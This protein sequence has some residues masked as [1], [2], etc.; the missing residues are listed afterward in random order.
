MLVGLL[1]TACGGSSETPPT[2]TPAP[3]PTRAVTA[4][5]APA[6]YT[7]SFEASPVGSPVASPESLTAG[8]STITRE[9]FKAQLAAAY[10]MEAAASTGGKIVFGSPADISTTNPM[11]ASDGTTLNILGQVFEP[12]LGASPIDGRPVPALADSWDVSPDGL[13]FTFHLNKAAKW[14]DGVDITTDDVQFSFDSEL[15]PN[16]GSPY[17]SQIREVIAS[18]RIIDADT[19]EIT[20]ADRFVT[21]LYNGPASVFILPKHIWESVPVEQWSFNGGSTGQDLARVVGSGPFLLTGWTVGERVVLTRNANYYDVVPSLDEFDMVIIPQA[22]TMVQSLEQGDID[23]VEILPAGQTAEVQANTALTVDVYPLQQ[24]TYYAMNLDGT[25]VP[26]F[27]DVRVRQAL[28]TSIDRQALTDSIFEG[29]GEPAR[30]TQ[31]P[32]SPSYDP[33]SLQPDYVYNPDGARKLLADAGWTDSNNNGSVDKDGTELKLT[34]IYT[35]GDSTVD[36]MV[37]YL[38]DAWKAIG[39]KV[40]ITNLNGEALVQRLNDHDFDLAILAISLSSDGSQGLLFDCDSVTTGFNFG[41]YCNQAY[42]DLDAQQLREF[43]PDKRTQMQTELAQIVW[44]D[45]P[46]GPIRFGVART[47]YSNRIHNFFPNGFGFLW[48][49]SYVWVDSGS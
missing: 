4:T 18:Y 15:N 21:F 3:M 12:L 31:P 23:L 16:L 32:L 37:E 45:L 42:D 2:V 14:S 11:L 39:V 48:S 40:E 46:V 43:D 38:Q 20:A 44:T 17:R 49:L 30:G 8:A 26:A 10:P 36:S 34:L 22:E 29:F 6:S 47:G 41:S 7:G 13:T 19:F 28:Y 27:S 25:K 35:G 24:V 5:L 1:V 9:E 33:N